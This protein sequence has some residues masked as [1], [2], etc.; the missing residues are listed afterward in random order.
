VIEDAAFNA[1]IQRLDRDITFFQQSLQQA[2]RAETA[3]IRRQLM[4]TLQ[5]KKALLQRQKEQVSNHIAQ[6]DLENERM[7]RAI[8]ALERMRNAQN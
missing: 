4:A 8:E 6:K 5:E 1:R 7:A 2:R 3:E